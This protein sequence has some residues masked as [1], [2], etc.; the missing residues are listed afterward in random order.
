MESTVGGAMK[1]SCSCK[2]SDKIWAVINPNTQKLHRL[3]FSKGLAEWLATTYG[4]GQYKAVPYRYIRTGKLF[5]DSSPSGLYAIVS[6][7]KDIVLRAT[8]FKEG[9]EVMTDESRHL[10]GMYLIPIPE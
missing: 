8:L 7:T 4:D 9:A 6:S 3:T 2:S 1:K 10:E 5:G